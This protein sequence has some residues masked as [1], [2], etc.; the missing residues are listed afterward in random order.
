[1]AHVIHLNNQY[2]YRKVKLSLISAQDFIW[3]LEFLH[4]ETKSLISYH[5]Q[6]SSLS[7]ARDWYMSVYRV[8][9]CMTSCKKPIPPSV[10]IFV[11]L[12]TEIQQQIEIRIP[13]DVILNS[14]DDDTLLNIRISDIKP[15]ILTLFKNNGIYRILNGNSCDRST[16]IDDFR[17]CWRGISSSYNSGEG[18][19]STA[20]STVISFKTPT[21]GDQIEW[22][23]DNEELIGPLLI[24]QVR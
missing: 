8:L 4:Y 24:E 11:M 21:A 14:N 2:P 13:L 16:T 17:L 19:A 7:E 20:N 9:P 22:I 5:F 6:S 10:D 1:L 15:V 3:C 18:A 12:Q 23:G